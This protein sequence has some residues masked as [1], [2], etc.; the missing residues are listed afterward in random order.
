MFYEQAPEMQGFEIVDTIPKLKKLGLALMSLEELCFDFETN[1]LRVY[2]LNEN[3]IVVGLA[4]S[5]GNSHNYY[6]PLGHRRYEDCLRNIDYDDFMKYIAPAFERED[7]RLIGHNLKFDMHIL[8]RLGIEIKTKDLFD[9][10]VALWLCDEND[11]KSLKSHA[12]K[13]LNI[14][15]TKFK[16]VV[17]DVPAFIK[18]EFGLKSQNKASF[19]LVLIDEGAP[20]ALADAFNTWKL[21]SGVLEHLENEGMSKIM[22]KVYVPLINTLF[23]MEERG[24]CIDFDKLE[25]MQD[26]IKKDLQALEYEMIEIAGVEFSPSSGQQKYELLFG[27]RKQDKKDKS[28]KLKKAKVNEEIIKHSFNFKPISMTDGGVPS[29]DGD[30]LL[31]LSRM[32]FKDKRKQEGVHLAKLLLEYSRL[33]K[34]DNSF[35]GGL[36]EKTYDDGKVHP[37]INIVGTDSGRYSCNDPNLQ[38]LPRPNENNKEYQV[39]DLYIGDLDSSGNRKKIISF[40]F[41]NLEMKVLCHFSEDENLMEMFSK[42][43][44]THGATAVNMFE[45]ECEAGEVKKQYPNLR[46]AAKTI[47]FLLMYGGSAF[48]LNE[49]LKNDPDSPIDLGEKHYLDLYKV[50]SGKDVAQYYIDKYFSSYSGVAEFIRHQKKFA[51]RKGYVQ[52]LLGRKRRLHNINSNDYKIAAYEERLS[53]NACIQ[54]SAGD[55]AMSAQNRIDLDQR[56]EEMEC[57]M[58]MQIH[59]EIL[60]E[61]PEEYVEEA[62]PIIKHYMEHPF[63]DKVEL[64]LPFTVDYGTGWSYQEAK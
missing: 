2:G 20:Y 63:G 36:K 33:S 59:D 44:D 28:G 19:D 31:T 1:T 53:V 17:N 29:V 8:V 32:T 60:F 6:I 50:K 18:K 48:T 15:A 24:M 56:F 7:V 49:K 16:E 23:K 27:Y 30:T 41:E 3:L 62:V 55:I 54:G 22:F 5:W 11:E 21:Y 12:M 9:I 64:N 57:Y 52:T 45:L 38:Q 4:I 34:L 13:K 25:V 26:N 46:Q 61:C 14:K 39:R 51:H 43:L 37:S 42:K 40:D 58:L 10:M 35:I 47:N